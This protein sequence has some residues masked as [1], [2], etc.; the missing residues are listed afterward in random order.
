MC[1][2]CG[3]RTTVEF[4]DDT[5]QALAHLRSETGMGVS[6]AVN[7]LV[8]RGLLA[9]A[10]PAPFIQQTRRLGIRIDVTNV[11]EAIDLLE[12]HEAR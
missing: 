5:A 9:E 8:R 3:V 4:D 11:A 6:E 2:L 12:G 1:I 7:T 10:P